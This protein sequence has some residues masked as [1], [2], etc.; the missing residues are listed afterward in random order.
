MPSQVTSYEMKFVSINNTNTRNSIKFELRQSSNPCWSVQFKIQ[1]YNTNH[2]ELD[3][4]LA[5]PN[6][7][8]LESELTCPI[9]ADVG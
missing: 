2:W 4:S 7:T 9:V 8:E 1:P 6:S 5:Y 3:S